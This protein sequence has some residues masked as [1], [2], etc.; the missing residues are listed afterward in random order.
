MGIFFIGGVHGV[1]KSSCGQEVAERNGLE[2]FTASA[3]IKAEQKSAIEENSKAVL[4]ADLNQKLLIH[5]IRKMAKC[6][7]K[8]VLL[9]GHFTLLQPSGAI[10]PI[11]VNVFEHLGLEGI[12]VFR[13]EPAAIYSRS[14]KRDGKAYSS[15]EIRIHQDMEINQAHRISSQLGIPIAI[16]N[17]FDSDGLAQTIGV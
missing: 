16:L 6:N 13:D 8:T 5:G 2:F 12:V 17:A 9:D 4:D 10:I 1:G 3:L 15:T 7:D 11:E 14:Q